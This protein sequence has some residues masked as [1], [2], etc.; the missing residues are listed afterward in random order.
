MTDFVTG[1]ISA[2]LMSVAFLGLLWTLGGA[3]TVP[4]FA[5]AV[6]GYMVYV[7][8]LY[9]AAGWLMIFLLGDGYADVVR[10]RNEAEARL[11]YELIHLREQAAGRSA[12]LDPRGSAPASGARLPM[13]WAHGRALRI[14][15][16]K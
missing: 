7:V 4:G 15:P 12:T 14:V 10:T 2:V 11:R 13:W 3:I 16:L 5:F 1:L 6:P 9:S 8:L